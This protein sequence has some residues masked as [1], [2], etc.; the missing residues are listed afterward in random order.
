M[1]TFSL[2]PDL[3]ARVDAKAARERRSRANM[4]EVLLE[5][6]LDRENASQEAA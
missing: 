4:I 6:S 5:E 1:L 3:V 2:P